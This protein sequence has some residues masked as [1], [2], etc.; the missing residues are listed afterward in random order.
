[1]DRAVCVLWELTL[2]EHASS[3]GKQVK[4]GVEVRLI[5]IDADAGQGLG[6]FENLHGV[7]APELFVHQLKKPRNAIMARRS[8]RFLNA[9]QKI[10]RQRNEE[11]G[12][13]GQP[14]SLRT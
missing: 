10:A 14:S 3:A 9:W 6:V 4:G 7:A 2:A 5:N 1:M 11:Y 12:R 13:R 8:G